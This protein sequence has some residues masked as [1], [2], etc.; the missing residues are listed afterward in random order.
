M[1]KKMMF[2]TKRKKL[3]SYV[4]EQGILSPLA[5]PVRGVKRAS[6]Q[7]HKNPDFCGAL[8]PKPL[9]GEPFHLR[10]TN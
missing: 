1:K 8:T 2:T 5:L 3:F 10:F 4:E 7:E 9:S 6:Q